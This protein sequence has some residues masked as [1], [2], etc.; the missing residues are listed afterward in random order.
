MPREKSGLVGRR[1][2]DLEGSADKG[3]AS[4]TGGGVLCIFVL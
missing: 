4:A 3:L 2:F 1:G